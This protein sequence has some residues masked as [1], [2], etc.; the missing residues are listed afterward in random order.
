MP[1]ELLTDPGHTRRD[2]RQLEAAIRN[3]EFEIPE[4]IFK[5]APAIIGTVLAKGTPREKTAAARVLVAMA[6]FNRDNAPPPQYIVQAHQHRHQIDVTTE[7]LDEH[8]RRLAARIAR[9]SND[10]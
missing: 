1:T 2:L 10:A 5:S 7:N 9:L 8:K 4:A 3:P 6:K